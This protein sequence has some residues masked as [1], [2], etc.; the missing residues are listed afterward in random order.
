MT[1][2]LA[3][4]KGFKPRNT[5]FHW[6]QVTGMSYLYVSFKTTTLFFFALITHFD[7]KLKMS[8][9]DKCRERL[10]ESTEQLVFPLSF[11][12]EFIIPK[13]IFCLFRLCYQHRTCVLL[14][15]VKTSLTIAQTG[16]DSFLSQTTGVKRLREAGLA[17][18]S[19][20]GINRAGL[21]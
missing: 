18:A 5:R 17:L 20:G 8:N 15:P 13:A 4:Q 3:P 1:L 2:R 12:I 16:C 7:F 14:N 19:T 11:Q 10:I 9:A 21:R 6:H